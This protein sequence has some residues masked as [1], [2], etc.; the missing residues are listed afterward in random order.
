MK[1]SQIKPA[2]SVLQQDTEYHLHRIKTLAKSKPITELIDKKIRQQT[3]VLYRELETLIQ[4]EINKHKIVTEHNN[5]SK[6]EE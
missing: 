5:K 1:S 3:Q 6:K 2:I 4:D